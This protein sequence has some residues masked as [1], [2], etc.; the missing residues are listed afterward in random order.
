[1]SN[2][3]NKQLTLTLDGFRGIDA[4]A[5]HADPSYAED[6]RNFR[7]LKDG[8]LQ[9]RCGYRFLADLNAPITA[10]W[11]GTVGDR[12]RFYLVA[13]R[14]VLFLNTDDGAVTQLGILPEESD[15]A[16][17]FFYLGILYLLDGVH[18]WEVREDKLVESAGYVPLIGKDWD[19]RYV[20]EFYEPKNVLTR[21]ARISYVISDP[22]SIFMAL[23][24]PLQSVDGVMVN[25][26][27]YSPESYYYD[28]NFNTVNI[29]NLEAGDRVT[30]HVTYAEGND[31]LLSQLMAASHYVTFGGANRN[32][33]FLWDPSASGKL[34]CSSYVGQS[35]L[36]ASKEAY[37][38]SGPL[39]FPV[40][41]EFY[42][43]EGRYAI[44][45]AE[46]HYDCL[47]IFTD[48]ELWIADDKTSG[49]EEFPT[50]VVNTRIGC[51]ANGGAVLAEN[52]MISV[53]KG[54]LWK[55]LN[56]TDRL[57]G[58]NAV[59][60][61]QAVD[62]LLTPEDFAS[63]SLYYHPMLN[64]LWMNI[65]LKK[66]ILIYHLTWG[67]WYRFGE[68][69]A[70]SLFLTDRS[71]GFIK[72]GRIFL[73]DETMREDQIDKETRQAITAEYMG[74]ITDFESERRKNLCRLTLR[75]DT[76]G[77]PISVSFSG[78]GTADVALT[79]AD[80]DHPHSLF[81]RRCHSGAFRH[82]QLKLTTSGT[83]R[84]VIHSLSLRAYT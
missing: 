79:L 12:F 31:D 42:V 20:G 63:M 1:M 40:G 71:F 6:V 33:L 32:R 82:G 9:K 65:P 81:R 68:I 23:D 21:R 73:F 11:A 59:R 7:I 41:S 51:A 44:R 29:M 26:E 66:E 35:E 62:P 72:G 56:D 30:I 52:D 3:T 47:L 75:A 24:A 49:F 8:S 80:P 58:R 43:G 38:D 25:G 57:L 53:G 61:S 28:E 10:H 16:C 83:G 45:A 14:K 64:E 50:T 13:D 4:T 17:F 39:Y 2:K 84:P 22:P 55:W 36:Y 77:D 5:G 54:T 76:D 46:P 67:Q 15:H 69:D 74:G 48:G 18:V 60:F 19:N 27:T 37:P 34:F 70:D 78:S